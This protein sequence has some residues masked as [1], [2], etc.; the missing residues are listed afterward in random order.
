MV[1][2][3]CFCFFHSVFL[4]RTGFLSPYPSVKLTH[5]VTTAEY[6][7]V[8]AI[9]GGPLNRLENGADRNLVKGNVKEMPNPAP[10]EEQLQTP[11]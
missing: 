3:F 8:L 11:E 9:Q 1:L 5:L 7:L 4:P 6:L 2:G 10:W